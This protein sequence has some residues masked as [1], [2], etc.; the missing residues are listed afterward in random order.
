MEEAH[1]SRY[2]INPS[3]M[4]MYHDIKE[5]YWLYVMKK[6]VAEFVALCPNCQYVK[7]EHQNPTDVVQSTTIA[8]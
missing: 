3:S 1:H 5:S 6:D 2:S 8:L 4:K 7:V